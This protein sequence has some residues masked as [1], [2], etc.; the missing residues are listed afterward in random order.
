MLYGRLWSTAAPAQM[1]SRHVSVLTGAHSVLG[2]AVTT[3]PITHCTNQC[4]KIMILKLFNLKKKKKGFGCLPWM[5]Y[6][7]ESH[8]VEL[9]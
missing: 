4:L 3:L 9:L 8:A 1:Q 2:N 6:L 7:L 5:G